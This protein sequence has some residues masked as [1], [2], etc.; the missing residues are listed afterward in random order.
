MLSPIKVC[1]IDRNESGG[2]CSGLCY[3]K[4]AM[5][6]SGCGVEN[7]LQDNGAKNYVAEGI[8]IHKTMYFTH[9]RP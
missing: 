3:N 5:K 2:I 8:S 6:I 4:M 7:C 1:I 9:F